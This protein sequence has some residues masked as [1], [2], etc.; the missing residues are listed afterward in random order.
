M[1]MCGIC[2]FLNLIEEK[3]SSLREFQSELTLDI[4][5]WRLDS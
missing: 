1:S 2:L 5:E 4:F 3:F